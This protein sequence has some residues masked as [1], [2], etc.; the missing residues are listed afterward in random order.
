M[1]KPYLLP[2][3]LLLVLNS[4][5]SPGI[6]FIIY[7][8]A[9]GY[10]A[11]MPNDRKGIKMDPATQARL[12]ARARVIKAM[13]HPSRLLIVEE[14]SKKERCVS[15]LTEMIEADVSTVSK[16][17]S[18]LKNVG[19][20]ADEKRGSQV[21]YKLV[22]LCILDFFKCAETVIDLHLNAQIKAR[23]P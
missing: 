9:L 16:H 3:L 6:F 17:L 11:I 21:Y 7:L 1:P 13:A 5:G 4:R 12:E 20:V 10:L 14:L 19:I 8:T 18:V 22:V 2:I 23:K 15:E